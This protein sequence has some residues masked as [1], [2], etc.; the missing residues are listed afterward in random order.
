MDD[1]KTRLTGVVGAGGILLEPE[2]VIF[3]WLNHNLTKPL[4]PCIEIDPW[5]SSVIGY[6]VKT[7]KP[8]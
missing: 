3:T 4:K 7:S 5:D 6:V 1:K 2:F 8:A